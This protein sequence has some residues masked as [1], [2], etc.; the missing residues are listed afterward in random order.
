[1]VQRSQ[2]S[3]SHSHTHF[4]DNLSNPIHGILT[5]NGMSITVTYNNSNYTHTN[6]HELKF[7]VKYGTTVTD[8][9]KM[10]FNSQVIFPNG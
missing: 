9:M 7:E 4:G 8:D 2:G 1:M 10:Y 3:F 5:K 6:V